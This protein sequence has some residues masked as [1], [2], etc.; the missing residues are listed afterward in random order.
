MKRRLK[1]YTYL[2]S[3]S[4]EELKD[5]AT[6]LYKDCRCFLHYMWVFWLMAAICAYVYPRDIFFITLLVVLGGGLLSCSLDDLK[7][8]RAIINYQFEKEAATLKQSE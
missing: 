2:E 3:F 7:T 1:D 6:R 4:L 5:Y 8:L